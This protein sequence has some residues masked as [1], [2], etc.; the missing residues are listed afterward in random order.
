MIYIAVDLITGIIE[1]VIVYMLCGTFLH[2]RE[3][4]RPWGYVICV[5]I[6][7]ALV[8]LSNRITNYGIL[9]AA[10]MSLS[11]F[12]LSATFK[13][14]VT[15][16]A[17][18]SVLT[19]LLMT[20]MEIIVMYSIILLFSISADDAV[21]VPV[22]RLLGIIVSKSLALLL[23]NLIRLKFKRKQILF[24]STY[25]VLFIVMFTISIT[26]MYLF[27]RLA[28]NISEDYLYNL[29]VLCSFGLLFS[30]FFAMYLYEH[31][32]EQAEVIYNQQQYEQHLK[33]QIK[34]MDEILLAQKQLRKFRHD[35]SHYVIGLKAYI[36]RK[37]FE[38]AK[39]YIEDISEKIDSCKTG[40][41][42]GNVALDALLSTK[43]ALAES[44]DI[45]FNL[46]V[47]IPERLPI[48]PLDLCVIFG[49]ALDN[50]IEAC[51]KI[52][53]KREIDVTIAMQND[54]L[55]CKIINTAQRGGTISQTSKAD[56][57]NH[58]FGLENIKTALAKYDSKPQIEYDDNKFT[59][60][61]V[62][63]VK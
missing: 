58:G 50:A 31:M 2:K 39:K 8:F 62:I 22:Y 32:A 10:G 30:T 19:F 29:V 60:K 16:K 24:N 57:N 49:N 44:K 37:D 9:N 34:H 27:F 17:V 55:F 51:D 36:E 26:V 1:A 3:N 14:K 7:G 25:W 63:C 23:A 6:T 42:T 13:G 4:I 18:I 41:N 35:L 40:I 12:A 46:K 11:F 5:I 48:E 52:S 56:K 45:L 21:N 61:F 33:E 54:F 20:I 43:K 59:L 38:Q 47:Q 53:E 15:T 28:D